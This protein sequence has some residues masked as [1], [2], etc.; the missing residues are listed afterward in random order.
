MK[1]G[2]VPRIQAEPAA[3]ND[4]IARVNA[5]AA[6]TE[7]VMGGLESFLDENR[8]SLNKTI[9]NAQKFS[10]ALLKMLTGLRAFCPVFPMW[11]LQSKRYHPNSM[12]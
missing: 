11:L 4:L 6:R 1:D 8:A 3:I 10:D 9:A 5:I 7:K 12:E 2:Q